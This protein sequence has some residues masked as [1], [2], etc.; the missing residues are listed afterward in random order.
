MKLVSKETKHSSTIARS[1]RS[2][3]R[4]QE[5]AGD[6]IHNTEFSLLLLPLCQILDKHTSHVSCATTLVC[7]S[8]GN[9]SLVCLWPLAFDRGF[10]SSQT[11]H[12][13]I[14][15]YVIKAY[16][17]P[18]LQLFSDLLLLLFYSKLNNHSHKNK[19]SLYIS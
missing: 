4:Q 7:I 17:Q 15:F 3:G 9:Q 8:E 19:S 16:R 14:I 5:T 10:D 1:N 2:T 13:H 11:T 18:F 12:S 6:T